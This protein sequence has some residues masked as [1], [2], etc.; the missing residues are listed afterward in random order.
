MRGTPEGRVN[1]MTTSV[2]L[3]QKGGRLGVT[4]GLDRVLHPVSPCQEKLS[5]QMLG[6]RPEGALEAGLSG[7]VTVLVVSEERLERSEGGLRG[8][9]E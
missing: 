9:S 1:N 3:L 5:G 6:Q 7:T 8:G 2:L 4:P